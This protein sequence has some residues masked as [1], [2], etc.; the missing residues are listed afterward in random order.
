MF[1]NK[2][3]YMNKFLK[4]S[5]NDHFNVLELKLIIAPRLSQV[6]KQ[7]NS[8]RIHSILW[9]AFKAQI[10]SNLFEKS[11]GD[12]TFNKFIGFFKIIYYTLY[13]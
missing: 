7:V 9:K 13:I 1:D 12:L 10:M 8:R 4:T 11:H 2:I 3:N 6:I 5:M